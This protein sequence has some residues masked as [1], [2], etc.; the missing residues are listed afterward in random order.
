MTAPPDLAGGVILLLVVVYFIHIDNKGLGS[1]RPDHA[2][3]SLLVVALVLGNARRSSSTWS[4]FILAL[5]VAYDFMRGVV[6][7]LA[8][9]STCSSRTLLEERLRFFRGRSPISWS[10]SSTR[11]ETPDGKHFLTTCAGVLR[12]A[13]WRRRSSSPGSEHPGC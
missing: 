12:D 8:E 9:R 4:P 3:L 7:D 5:W 11:I 10:R 1:C 2:F 13:L 6:D